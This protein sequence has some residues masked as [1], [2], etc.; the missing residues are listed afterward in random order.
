MKKAKYL[1]KATIFLALLIVLV[2]CNPLENDT[3]SN[4][5]LIIMNLTGQ[6]IDGNTANFLQSDVITSANTVTADTATVTFKAQLLNPDPFNGATQYNDI[7]VTHYVVTYF[8]SDGKNT[9]GVDI[10][11]SFEGYMS[12]LIEIDNITDLSFVL[13]REVAKLEP[14]LINLHEGRGEGV[15][16]L[17]AK[18]DFYGHD[19]SNKAIKSTGYLSIYFA[20]Y[21]D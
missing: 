8:R 13:V 18:V 14:P 6:D 4:S 2:S 15:L 11:Y 16:Q 21:A 9:E 19:L 3:L 17:R 1:F 12:S 7:F 20:N 10:P 5:M